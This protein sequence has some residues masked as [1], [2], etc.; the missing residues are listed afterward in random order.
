M[1]VRRL[2]L[3]IA[4]LALPQPA[5]LHV[6]GNL[7]PAEVSTPRSPSSSE[8]STFPRRP[9]EVVAKDPGVTVAKPPE[10]P[11][12]EPPPL[13]DAHLVRASEPIPPVSI[14]SAS[15]PPLL[16][17][18]KAYLDN[19]P[20]DAIRALQSLDRASQDY[21]IAL[22][23]L[24]VRGTQMNLSSP[25]PDETA[26]I[27]E[28]LHALAA[29]LETKAALR[30]EKVLF[31]RKAEGFGQYE[32][33]VEGQP[34]KP[35]DLARLYIE[36]R[37]VGSEP[38]PGPSGESYLSRATVS[39]EVR[40]AKNNLVDQTDPKD[41]RR[42]VPIARYDHADYTRSMPHDYFR[43]YRFPVPTQPG[44]YTVTVEVKDATGRMARSQPVEFRVAGP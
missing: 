9:G 3:L 36:L 12:A 42:R 35:N 37:N 15:Q 27:V 40:D 13:T 16:T 41:Y 11:P 20:E 18:L 2:L 38:N 14:P 32:P 8:F 21:A 7:T 4:A 17:A 30:V 23:P 6:S 25:P 34:Y 26:V 19:R 43:T 39:L 5:C 24:L 1:P 10:P 33:W 28:R 44:V 22:M 29:R 31:C